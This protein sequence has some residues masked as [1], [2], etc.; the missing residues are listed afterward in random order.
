MN[1]GARW[2]AAGCR[3]V[4]PYRLETGHQKIFILDKSNPTVP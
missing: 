3:P 1:N 4:V 2:G